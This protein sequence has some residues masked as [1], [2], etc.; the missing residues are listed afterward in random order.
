MFISTVIP[1]Y[2]KARHIEETIQSV[3]KQSH[4]DFEII[5]VDDG[6]TDNGGDVVKQINDPRIKLIRQINGGVSKAR[7]TGIENSS[8]E[9]IAFLD[10]DD[11]WLPSHLETLHR[12][13]INFPN[14]GIY[15]TAYLF[16]TVDKDVS[17]NIQCIPSTSFEG[18]VPDYFKSNALGDNLTWSSAVAVKKSIFEELGMFPVG[19]RMGEDQDMW[20][21]IALKYP[22]CFSSEVSAIYHWE[23]DNRA[24]HSFQEKDLKSPIL[25]TWFE[26]NAPGYL[27]AYILRQQ[28][29]L[30]KH[31]IR[32]GHGSSTRKILL[33][34]GRLHGLK[35]I[36][37]YLLASFLTTSLLNFIINFKHKFKM[38]LSS[39]SSFQRGNRV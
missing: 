26:W 34:I 37:V 20:A 8:Y 30:I 4:Q 18:I 33:R 29:G 19:V 17:L 32:A 13:A 21:R 9:L 27:Q 12:M 2:N 14:V 15:S 1:L 31:I 7:N 11:T 25:T 35:H 23:T 10:G 24:C 38:I 28:L 22:V 39:F 6:S 36:I 5:V 16:R 3:L